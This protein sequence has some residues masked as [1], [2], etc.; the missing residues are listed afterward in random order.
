MFPAF[1]SFVTN[2]RQN[3]YFRSASSISAPASHHQARGDETGMDYEKMKALMEASRDESP[4]QRNPEVKEFPK[5]ESRLDWK[6]LA[7]VSKE[8]MAA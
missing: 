6:C 3:L 8:R 7:A 2:T 5:S 1:F 4:V